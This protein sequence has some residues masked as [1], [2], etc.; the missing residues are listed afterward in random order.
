MGGGEVEGMD[1]RLLL[2]TSISF[3]LPQAFPSFQSLLWL[4]NKAASL[5]R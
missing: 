1:G 5:L 4:K 2:Y 3:R